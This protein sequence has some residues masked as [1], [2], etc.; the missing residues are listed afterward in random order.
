MNKQVSETQQQE[1]QQLEVAYSEA[2]AYA[3]ELEDQV[4]KQ[5][6]ADAELERRTAKLALV[7]GI[8]RKITGILSVDQLLNTT[9]SLIQEMFG[10]DHVGLYLKQKETVHLEA[11]SGAYIEVLSNEAYPVEEIIAFVL[12]QSK[13]LLLNDIREEPRFISPYPEKSRT[14]AELCLP[15]MI[16]ESALGVLDI[17]CFRTQAFDQDDV[18][19][20]ESLTHQI[21]VALENARLHS[22]IQEELA[23]RKETERVLHRTLEELQLWADEK[24]PDLERA[25]QVLQQQIVERKR[26]EAELK[27]RA[28]QQA[29]V[30]KFGQ[31]VL[32]GIPLHVLLDEAVTLIT[33]TLCVQYG[34]ILE[35]LPNV[36]DTLL[37]RAGVGWKEG[38]VGNLEISA[39]AQ[40]QMGYTLLSSEPIIVE[41]AGAEAR[42][43]I[44]PY[45]K[46]HEVI[47]SMSV[48]IDGEPWPFGVLGVCT[49]EHRVFT[50]DDINFL[51]SV[52]NIL[53]QATERI[54]AEAALRESE[55]KYRTLIEKSSDAIFLIYGGRFEVVNR[56]FTELFGVTQEE[57]NSPDFVFTNIISV[58]GRKIVQKL[59]NPERLGNHNLSPPPYEFS[60]IDKDGN[61]IDVELSVS[62]PTY[63][64]G[65]AT[66]GLIRDITERKR[67][68]LEK[69]RA[70]EKVQQFAVELSAKVEEEQ[71]QREIS[72]ILAEV[73]ASISLTLATDEI[74]NHILLKLKQLV[75]YDSAAIFLVKDD[76]YLVMEA[77]QGFEEDVTNQEFDYSQNVLF[78]EM[79]TSKSA[80]YIP[81]TR[82]DERYQFW[83]GASHVRCWIGAP[84]LVA[85]EMIGY[86]TVDRYKPEG[87]TVT[88]ANV[89]QA[90]AHQVAQTIYNARLFE[91]LHD[92]QA[93]LIQRE[94]LAALGQMAATVAHELRN[95]LMAIKIGVEY[96]VHDI[97][98]DDPRKRGASLMQANMER[99]D[100]IIDDILYV[101]RAPKPNLVLGSLYTVLETETTF[102]EVNL[103][104]KGLEFHHQLI[105]DPPPIMVDFDQIGR[106]FSN[107]ISNSADAVGAGGEV[108]L[109]MTVD[110]DVQIIT[111]E[112]NGPGISPEHQEK[113]FEPFFT[114]KSRGTGLGLAIV[115]Q[116]VENH[117][118]T[119]SLW[120][121]LEVGTKFTI[122]LP[123]A[124][125]DPA[126]N[127]EHE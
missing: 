89:I 107:L 126:S 93:Q 37:L 94:R 68:E 29:V 55:E 112:D 23:E 48:L 61:E 34:Q 44:S 115:K 118:G 99:I 53:A 22:T 7:S 32:A 40:S 120:S 84:L 16:G 66:Q 59:Q 20:L 26:A 117:H 72:T 108:R 76:D 101:A 88:D 56:R 121:E 43:L 103:P 49:T 86:V 125:Y 9:V 96:L 51:Q 64:G 46:E 35:L 114:T 52:A 13:T 10:Y 81:D 109:T 5:Q 74:L 1:I 70:Y 47:S 36:E 45:L 71:R 78:R 25:N 12:N 57:A 67:I 95:P 58:R 98:E 100:R 18:L 77:A 127:D 90:F 28:Y 111:V 75:P 38:L 102:W 50:H 39:D 105:S 97:T 63:R 2:I 92:T 106:V 14:E 123:N 6:H 91:Q 85:Q 104:E 33:E 15:I 122:T 27:T 42:F 110:D 11:A 79:H 3:Q 69:Q 80:I 17:Q 119:I 41:D 83:S 21:A 113:I 87:L 60:A 82:Y 4:R 116:I 62:Y 8:G 124:P 73:V 19:A 24:A 31:R 30:A 65:L 54:H